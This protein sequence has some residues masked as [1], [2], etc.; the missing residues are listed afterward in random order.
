MRQQEIFFER[1]GSDRKVEILKTY[2]TGA[3]REAFSAM[4]DVARQVLWNSLD[5]GEP[6]ESTDEDGLWSELTEAAREDGNTLSFFV[7]SE[8]SGKRAVA[9]YVSPDYPSAEAFAE[10]L[11]RG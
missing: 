9:K 4:D 7:V 3:A 2:D 6:F 10:S 5:V 8:T 11:I 1:T